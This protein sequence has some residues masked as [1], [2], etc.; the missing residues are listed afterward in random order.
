QRMDTMENAI[1]K[2]N[3]KLENQIEPQINALMEGQKLMLET[4][5]PRAKV[6]ELEDRVKFLEFRRSSNE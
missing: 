6:D 3:I 4:L 5:A 2:I 1:L